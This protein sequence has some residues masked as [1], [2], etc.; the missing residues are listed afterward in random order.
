MTIPD[1]WDLTFV[2]LIP[3]G[4]LYENDPKLKLKLI[5]WSQIS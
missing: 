4:I 1:K 2:F 3:L 5:T